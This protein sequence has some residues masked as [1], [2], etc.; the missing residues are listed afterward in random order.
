VSQVHVRRAGPEDAAAL[1]ELRAAMSARDGHRP[2]CPD[3]AWRTT[4]L[5]GCAELVDVSTLPEAQRRGHTRAGVEALM[6]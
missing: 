3:A 6:T 1:V 5:D 4:A 2:G